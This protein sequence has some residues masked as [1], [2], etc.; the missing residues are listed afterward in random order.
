MLTLILDSIQKL[1]C[2]RINLCFRIIHYTG[3][4]T[5]MF[6]R[7]EEFDDDLSNWDV[8][9]VIDT[10]YMFV[11]TN[12]FSNDISKWDMSRVTSMRFMFY[13]A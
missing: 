13:N 4:M 9:R 5:G 8:S 1:L 6:T 10:Y 12:S 7:E 3:T 11:L 2:F